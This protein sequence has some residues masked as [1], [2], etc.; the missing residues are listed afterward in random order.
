MG[1]EHVAGQTEQLQPQCNVEDTQRWWRM[2]GLRMPVPTCAKIQPT[3]LTRFLG[4]SITFRNTLSCLDFWRTKTEEEGRKEQKQ[5]HWYPHLQLYH[6]PG[7]VSF[8][9]WETNCHP[10]AQSIP[11]Q[12]SRGL[13]WAPA[14]GGQGSQVL[15]L[16]EDKNEMKRRTGSHSQASYRIHV[17]LLKRALNSCLKVCF[18]LLPYKQLTNIEEAG[19]QDLCTCCK[20][21]FMIFSQSTGLILKAGSCCSVVVF[22]NL[23]KN[24]NW[25]FLISKE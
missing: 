21:H 23:E 6:H 9:G 20:Q 14:K 2:E 10:V 13:E 4:P 24:I 18:Q 16:L 11:D 1:Y 22:F 25:N 5:I 17:R 3:T 8:T 7:F 12:F 19:N 15:H